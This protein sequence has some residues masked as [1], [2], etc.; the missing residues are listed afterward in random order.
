MKV[1][2]YGWCHASVC[3]FLKIFRLM[4]IRNINKYYKIDGQR[5]SAIFLLPVEDGF[6]LIGMHFS[7]RNWC[8]PQSRFRDHCRVLMN[9]RNFALK[10]LLRSTHAI[11]DETYVLVS[12]SYSKKV[13]GTIDRNTKQALLV[14][15][16]W[17]HIKKLKEILYNQYKTRALKLKVS[18]ERRLREINQ[19]MNPRKRK[20]NIKIFGKVKRRYEEFLRIAETIAYVNTV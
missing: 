17:D 20:W 15:K 13:R 16:W 10:K 3:M 5:K 12:N 2:N 8:T 9:A 1:R 18:A 19:A 11:H 4:G 6:H 14:L 7:E